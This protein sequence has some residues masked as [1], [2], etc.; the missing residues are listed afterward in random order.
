MEVITDFDCSRLVWN[1]FQ[2]WFWRTTELL[3][4]S[5]DLLNMY[6]KE[7]YCQDGWK[8]S[9]VVFVFQNIRERSAGQKYR[10]ISFF[11]L[12]VNF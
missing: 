7:S 8:V 9:Y 11:Q 1:V 4:L 10:P 2:R 6:L 5:D 3:Y 12:L